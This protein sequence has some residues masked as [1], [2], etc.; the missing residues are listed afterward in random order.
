MTLE[1]RVALVTGAG[2]GIGAAI[3][4]YLGRAGA[5]VA[6]NDVDPE[7]AEEVAAS[8]RAAGRRAQAF[9]VSVVNFYDSR[10]M[11]DQIISEYGFVDILVSG[12]GIAT[13]GKKIIG[14]SLERAREDMDLFCFAAMNLCQAVLPSMRTLGRGDI[15]A[16]SSG[17][18][19]MVVDPKSSYGS[20]SGTYSMAKAALE[21][22]AFTL[23]KEE[24]G[25]GI[26]VNV[27]APL[28]TDTR[29]VRDGKARIIRKT[30]GKE[31]TE[32]QLREGSEWLSP[33]EGLAEAVLSFVS[34]PDPA[35]TCQKV[36]VGLKMPGQ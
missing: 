22:L 26:R 30:T 29:M 24:I 19:E 11:V 10:R 23:A 1:G 32:E 36:T 3:A 15:I 6:V 17:A 21:A 18:V 13:S 12:A 14:E 8:I 16:I 34:D 20:N 31:P 27:V 5:V 28:A 25:H 9:P 33:P 4:H 2:R 7:P 35:R